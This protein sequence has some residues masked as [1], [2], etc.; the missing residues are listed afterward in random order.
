VS[1]WAD[2]KIKELLARVE[3]LEKRKPV[4]VPDLR[5][6]LDKLKGEIQGLKMRMGKRGHTD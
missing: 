3:E 1:L 2:A 5:P 4:E 6:E